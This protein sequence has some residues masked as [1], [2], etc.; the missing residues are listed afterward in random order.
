MSTNVPFLSPLESTGTNLTN[1]NGVIGGI[2]SWFGG[3]YGHSAVPLGDGESVVF[4]L[5]YRLLLVSFLTLCALWRLML[6]FTDATHNTG[7]GTT[8]HQPAGTE[9]QCTS[10][11]AAPTSWPS[12]RAAKKG[13][14]KPPK[15]G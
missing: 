2:A 1:H 5:G 9:M 14:T 12:L 13:S 10:T 4:G 8:R 3:T 7:G 6:K 15:V 11:T